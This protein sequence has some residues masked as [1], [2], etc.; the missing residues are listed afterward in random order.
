MA[1][2]SIGS[3]LWGFDMLL[4]VLEK[5]REEYSIEKRN[6]DDQ[7]QKLS[8]LATCVDHAHRLFVKVPQINGQDRGIHSC[9]DTQP[10]TETLLLLDP[11]G[12]K[13]S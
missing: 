9:N 3:V 2:G 1:L 8:H 10:M 11:L 13:T 5:M 7:N 6:D 4:E 12:Q